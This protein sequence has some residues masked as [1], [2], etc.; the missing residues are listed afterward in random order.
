MSYTFLV[1][2]RQSDCHQKV[3]THNQTFM[4]FPSMREEPR[5]KLRGIL[6]VVFYPPDVLYPPGT[7]P[8]E[9]CCPQTP[10]CH[11]PGLHYSQPF[12]D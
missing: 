9:G 7:S 8:N 11:H 2:Q 10:S 4:Y 5:S 1:P 12:V 3:G 6:P